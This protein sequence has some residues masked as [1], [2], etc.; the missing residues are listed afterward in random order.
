MLT[1]S[2]G[3]LSLNGRTLTINSTGNIAASGAGTITGSIAS[4]LVINSTSGLTSALRFTSGSSTLGNLTLNTATGGAMLGSDL[5]VNGMLTLSAGTLTL[6]GHNLSLNGAADVASS[7]TG[8]ITGSTTSNLI[9]NTTGSVTGA[10]RFASGANTLNNVTITT[11]SGSGLSLGSDLNVN[12]MLTLTAGTLSLNGHNLVLNSGADLSSTG[13]GTIT[14]STTSGLT[15]NSTTG[16]TGALRFAAGTGG[17]LNTLVVNTTT[18]GATLGSDLNIN[19]MLTL[20]SGTLSLNGHTLTINS[21][22]NIAASGTGTITGSATADL[23]INSTSG[24]TGAL[25]FT[26]GSSALRNL[27]LNT[28]S[29]GA[30]LGTDLGVTGMLT[31]SSGTLT[32]NGHNFSLNGAADFA[33]AGTGTITGSATSNLMVNTTGS[34]TGA[35]RFT[36]GANTLNNLDVNMTTGGSSVTMGSDLMINGMLNLQ[37]GKVMLGTNNLA[38][39]TGGTVTG[40][41]ANSYV[42]TNGTGVLTMN[43]AASATDTFKVGSATNFAPIVLA[44]NTGASTGNVSVQAT[45][46]VLAGGTSGASLSATQSM[47]NATWFV[48]STASSIDYN[49]TAMWSAGMEVNG[50]NRG[51]A[52]ISHYTGGAWDATTASAAGTSGSMYTMSRTG[53]TSLSPFMV[54]DHAIGTTAIGNVAT[55][56]PSILVYPNP[57]INVLHF[58]TSATVENVAIYDVTGNSVMNASA[59]G[60]INISSLP[61]G[62]YEVRFTGNN[63]DVVQKFIK[64]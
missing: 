4:G 12:G 56:Q 50:F 2:S 24:L 58:S 37:S 6:N 10:L 5:S 48:S 51:S 40:G 61:A 31:L 52:F 8:T 42:V 15:V 41:S 7:G 38:I 19:S 33:S 14:G 30:T 34:I 13:T 28:A 11:G 59:N 46:G 32:L 53:I 20:S 55:A 64:Q 62:T 36:T 60:D 26:T 44:A 45:D 29:G 25:R 17:T 3:T 21:T 16:L 35:L 63:L 49:M 54:T 18:G 43:L 27:T 9:V 39:N 23:V 57:A 47:V 22:G 1:L